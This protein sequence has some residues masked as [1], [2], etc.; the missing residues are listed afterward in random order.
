M[1]K[2]LVVNVSDSDITIALL[3]E[4]KLVELH[5]EQ[6]NAHFL[7]G[8]IYLGKVKKIMPGL[9]AAFVDVG[10]VKDAFLHYFDLGPQFLTLNKLVKEVVAGKKEIGFSKIRLEKDTEKDGKIEDVLTVGQPILVQIAKEPISTKGPRVS[11]EVSIAY[12]NMVLIPFN[13][14]ISISQKIRSGEEKKRLR[15]LITSILP[16]NFGVI[17]RTA[18]EGKK[19]ATLNSEIDA[20]MQRWQECLQKL[21]GAAA[22]CLVVT[23]ISRTSA[24]LRDLLSGSFNSVHINDK[25]LY[26]EVKGYIATIAPEKTQIVHLY[27]S[28][29]PIFEHFGLIK[30][31]KSGFGRIVSVKNGIY[32][33]IEHTEALHVIDVNSGVRATKGSEDQEAVALDVNMQAAEEI[34]R[35]LRL[36]DMGGIIVVDFIDLYQ[37]ANRRTLFLKMIELMQ[38][39]RA[40]HTI[41]PLSK[42]GLMQITRQRVRPEMKVR[43]MEQCPCCN[44][45]GKVGPSLLFD[46]QIEAKLVYFI[47]EKQVKKITLTVHP[48]VA[49]YLRKGF[50]SQI[51]KWNIKHKCR[52]HLIASQECSYL[53]ARFYNE[54]GEEL[55]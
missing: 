21:R 9:N 51:T 55:E 43:T 4:K 12:R 37:S 5:K 30:S 42:F 15:N 53:E 23:E 31:I 7:V 27:T 33:V 14:K 45:S 18:G 10:Y 50:V 2:D 13:N 35:Q 16:R 34:A 52:I 48:Y 3:E 28:D 19:V 44:G 26:E 38:D 8:D 36:R 22:P 11:A 6:N 39:D 25:P 20:A 41:L 24:I 49:A 54:T 1:N 40:K 17:V 47:T 46:Q 32:L 29:V